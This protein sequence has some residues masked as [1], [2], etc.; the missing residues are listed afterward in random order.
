MLH[1]SAVEF[2]GKAVVICG[3]EGIGKTSLVL[4]LLQEENTSFLSD[5]L[6][7]Y[8]SQ[9]IYPCYELIR[10][11]KHEDSS[12]WRAKF[13]KVNEFRSLKD[14]YK[15]A[16]RLKREGVQPKI[17]VFPQFSRKFFVKAIFG[18]DIVH[19]AAIM[20]KLPAELGNYSEFR[21]LYNFS[22]L[23]FNPQ[24]SEYKALSDLLNSS[25]CYII[26]MPKADGLGINSQRLKD[27]IKHEQ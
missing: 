17:F 14:F 4:S 18:P 13:K 26:G 23:N 27:F 16:F 10:I 6:I 7:F 20:S 8:D 21:K 3:M 24:K 12:L 9:R 5:N 2:D 25:R 1:A 22:D 11:H 19:K 15:P